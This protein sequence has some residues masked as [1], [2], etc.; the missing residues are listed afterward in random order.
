M[1]CKVKVNRHGFLAFRLYWDSYE[2]WEGTEWRD[3]PKNRERA[4]A[5]AVLISEQMDNGSFDYLKWFPEGNKAKQFRKPSTVDV[6]TA[7]RTVRNYY[8]RW[9]ETKQPPLV[10]KSL[11][12]DYQQ[13]FNCYILPHLG[14]KKLGEIDAR[15][16]EDLKGELLKR[17]LSISTV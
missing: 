8:E 11:A 10:R 9:V 1:A 7:D 15:T 17:N 12:R 2:S 3:T 4:Q 13:Y 16:L 14:D 5:R 6:S